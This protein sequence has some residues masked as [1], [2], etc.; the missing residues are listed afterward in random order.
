M[1]RLTLILGLVCYS[2]V[3][4][5]QNGAFGYYEDALRFGQSD[6]SLGSTARM[7]AIGGAQI[8]LGGDIS[9]AI[10]NPA[11]L[12]FFN[13]SVFTVSP[14]LNFATSDTR[15]AIDADGQ[16]FQGIQENFYNN[17]NFA[18]IGT[19]INWNTG[20]FSDDPF[21]GGSLA[22]S[23]SRANNFRLNRSYEGE[24]DFNS[25]ADALA[26]QSF[27]IDPN[28][29]DELAYAAYDQ[30]LITPFDDN[31]NLIY[32]ADFDGFPV[33][34]ESIEERG[35]H[36]QMNIAWGGNYDD[37]FYFGGGMGMQFLNYRQNRI[38]QE[39]DFGN[40]TGDDQFIPDPRLNG[41][42]LEDDLDIRGTG[43]NFNLGFIARPVPFMTIG[44]SYTSPSF[45][46]FSEESFL[47]LDADWKAGAT[48]LEGDDLSNIDPYQSALFVS[49]YSLRTPSKVGLGATLFVGKSGF[50][51]G[52]LEF[53]DYGNA[54]INSND[55]L[56]SGDNQVI[57][58]IYASVMN[59]RV[60]GEYRIQS[61]RLRAGYA[62]LPS[63]Y[64]NSNL[65]EQ[66]AVSFGFGY[67]TSD[68]FL[69]FAIVNRN[70]N[71]QYVPYEV[72]ENQPIVDT[73][74]EN[75]VFTVTWGLNF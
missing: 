15:Y 75:T 53:V 64:Q 5:S 40:K 13:K 20:R 70:R 36:Y 2:V 28:D 66:T 22:I 24:N 21:K 34:N 62:F 46:S 41:F 35:S 54:T 37:R 26:D 72:F 71:I 73:E 27:N 61:F 10:S 17:F 47:D 50:L 51:S 16:G 11:G 52:D 1:K 60:G 33:Q 55:F 45:I 19:V 4:Y 68:Y 67:R 6:Y 74:I 49:N 56:T 44:A 9:S 3:S 31:G 43:V 32:E 69:D 65:N 7:Q 48:S 42:T 57:D 29:L 58:N 63:P 8:S 14:S 23:I 39:F 38:Y 18:N 30:Y 25:L 12:G 59:V